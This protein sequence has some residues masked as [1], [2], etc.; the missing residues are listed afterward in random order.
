MFG[1]IRK[2]IGTSIAAEG[3][4]FVMLRECHTL[5]R[6]LIAFLPCVFVAPAFHVYLFRKTRGPPTRLRAAELGLRWRRCEGS[7]NGIRASFDGPAR[8]FLAPA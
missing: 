4:K 6:I 3:R 5:D 7:C 2:F 1:D 8:H